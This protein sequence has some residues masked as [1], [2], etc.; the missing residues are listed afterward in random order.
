[1]LKYKNNNHYTLHMNDLEK[2]NS[3]N[4][5]LNMSDSTAKKIGIVSNLLNK[6]NDFFNGNPQPNNNLSNN[7]PRPRR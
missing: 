3:E 7:N 5:Q 2:N 4:H 1:M 6:V